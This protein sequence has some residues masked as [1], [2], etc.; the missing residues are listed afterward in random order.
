[1]AD[2][3]QHSCRNEGIKSLGM[4]AV[5][6]AEYIHGGEIFE[7]KMNRTRKKKKK[8]CPLGEKLAC[9]RASESFLTSTVLLHV[10]EVL[11]PFRTWAASKRELFALVGHITSQRP[12]IHF[13]FNIL[14]FKITN[15]IA[16]T[17]HDSKME[18]YVIM[19]KIFSS[20]HY[21]VWIL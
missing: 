20:Q 9:V 2:E 1:M 5:C 3:K 19:L 13:K 17:L 4:P 10:T 16:S 8:T 7:N 18:I 14:V 15:L 21:E 6:Y 12:Q 11:E